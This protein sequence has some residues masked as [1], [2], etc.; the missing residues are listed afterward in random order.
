ML[1]RINKG[2]VGN[3]TKAPCLH[4]PCTDSVHLY[5]LPTYRGFLVVQLRRVVGVPGRSGKRMTEAV[6]DADIVGASL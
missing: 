1:S 3:L 2:F 6:L 4:S 5:K